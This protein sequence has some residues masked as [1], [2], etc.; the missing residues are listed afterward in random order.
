MYGDIHGGRKRAVDSPAWRHIQMLRSII[1][2]TGNIAVAFFLCV[3]C[4]TPLKVLFRRNKLVSALNR[5]RRTVGLACFFYASLHLGIYLTNGL[6]TLF[7]EITRFYIAA[8][9]S[10]FVILLVLA[11]TSNNRAQRKLGGRKWKKLHRIVSVIFIYTALQNLA[12]GIERRR[13]ARSR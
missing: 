4:L 3:L 5:H 2:D 6:Q 11:L 1:D 8:G 7:D 10:A 13:A 9:L 12:V